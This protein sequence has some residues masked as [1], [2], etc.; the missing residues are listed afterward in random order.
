MSKGLHEI[1]IEVPSKL[2]QE[3]RRNFIS[4]SPSRFNFNWPAK[5]E[6]LSSLEFCFHVSGRIFMYTYLARL[7]VDSVSANWDR[8]QGPPTTMTR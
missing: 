4:R 8:A 2:K 1:P 5:K 6:I 3:E 7:T